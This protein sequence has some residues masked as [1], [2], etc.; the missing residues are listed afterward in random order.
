MTWGLGFA[1]LPRNRASQVLVSDRAR[2]P[3]V[4]KLTKA[5]PLPSSLDNLRG[6]KIDAQLMRGGYRRV[7]SELE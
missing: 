7:I 3:S 4:K 6:K 1:T 5:P 2:L